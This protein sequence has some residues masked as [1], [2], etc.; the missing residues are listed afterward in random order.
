MLEA[1]HA[2]ISLVEA[3]SALGATARSKNQNQNICQGWCGGAGSTPTHAPCSLNPD[4]A[5]AS[6]GGLV[7]VSATERETVVIS[8]AL[9]GRGP[10]EKQA[11]C[12]QSR[13][14][15]SRHY[16]LIPKDGFVIRLSRTSTK[17][18]VTATKPWGSQ[19]NSLF[20]PQESVKMFRGNGQH[21][22]G[23]EKQRIFVQRSSNIRPWGNRWAGSWGWA[24]CFSERMSHLLGFFLDGSERFFNA[25]CF[26]GQA[27]H[28]FSHF[29]E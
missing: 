18:S 25:A 16:R 17:R 5:L 13:P 4:S 8:V 7:S 26:S 11:H 6:Q 28:F 27:S 21:A 10:R 20:C 14:R 24:G 9:T 3:S 23:V 15:A 2:A 19:T 1:P 12:A 22:E 29:V